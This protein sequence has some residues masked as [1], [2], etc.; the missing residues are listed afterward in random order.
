MRSI[1][2]SLAFAVCVAVAGTA[3]PRAHAQADA[4]R[5]TAR[6]L[7]QDGEA[8]LDRKDYKTAE[9]DFRRA[10]SL[11]HAPTLMLGLARALAGEGK[12]VAAQ[13]AYMRIIR[14]GVPPGAPPAFTKALDDA[15]TE[16]QSITPRIGGMTISVQAAGGGTVANVSVQL[17]GAP[18]S[19]ASLGVK[20]AVDPGAHV[21]HV[22]AD[23]YKTVDLKVNVVPGATAD[24]PVSLEKD[25]SATPAVVPPPATPA[26]LPGSG[27]PETPPPASGGHKTIW[28][29]VAFGV[30][31]AGLGLGVVTGVLAIG[32]HSTLSSECKGGSCPSGDSGDL[33]SYHTLGVLSTVGFIVAGVGAAAG[34]TLLILQP[35]DSS[36]PASAGLHVMPVIGPGSV[37]AVGTF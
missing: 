9:D 29:W 14:E 18:V 23:G 3:A 15:K 21:V 8:A 19:A 17:D 2:R 11:V 5:A 33:S 10:D 24:A 36:P 7:G 32:K 35:K 34:I 31:G 22:S 4:D 37:G 13:E 12:L 16:V 20:R 26:P 6:S 25:A 28:P 30:G 27:E 1:P